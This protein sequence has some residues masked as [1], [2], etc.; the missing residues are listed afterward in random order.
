MKDWKIVSIILSILILIEL[1]LLI[2]V[3]K[4]YVKFGDNKISKES[5]SS[6]IDLAEQ[7]KQNSEEFIICDMVKNKCIKIDTID[8]FN[9]FEK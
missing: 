4:D 8:K 5:I 7:S 2:S 6:L 1:L 3:Q 9:P